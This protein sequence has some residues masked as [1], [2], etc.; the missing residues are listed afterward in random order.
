MSYNKYYYKNRD[1]ILKQ[2]KEYYEKNKKKINERCKQYFKEYYEKNKETIKG[3]IYETI[4][5]NKSENYEA[6]R[7]LLR[8]YAKRFY[9]K[10]N[11]FNMMNFVDTTPKKKVGRPKGSK[12]KN[13]K[14]QKPK[15]RDSF[16]INICDSY[17]D[18]SEY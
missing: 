1:T 5:R 4:K 8:L 11:G 16:T 17:I 3:R 9:D 15:Q 10:K 7:L 14:I 18:F 12:T 2:R 6:F 13:L